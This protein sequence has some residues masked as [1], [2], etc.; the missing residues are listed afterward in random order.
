[1]LAQL[2]DLHPN[3]V[4]V[5]FRHFPLLSIHDKASLAGQA[6][7][8]AGAQ[9][10]FWEMH[11]F[12]FD[13]YDEWTPLSPEEF[14]A[15]LKDA[16]VALGLEANQFA[17]DLDSAKYEPMMEQAFT[18]SL[19]SGLTGTPAILINGA[20]FRLSPELSVLEATVR[21]LLLEEMQFEVYPEMTITPGEDFIARLKLDTGE[22]VIQLY[23]DEAPQAVNSFIFLAQSGWYDGN[24][25][26]L[27]I[28]ETL[29][30][31][32]DPSGTGF[33]DPG[34]HFSTEISQDLTFDKPGMVA[35]TSNGPD[36]N[37]S[38]FFITLSSLPELDGLHTIIGRVI[39]GLDLLEALEARDPLEDIFLA[40]DAR[41]DE[42][43]IEEQ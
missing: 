41:I 2:E 21:L 26:H 25:I 40:P 34:Y 12:L 4:Q 22:V 42:I 14:I 37:G 1:M 5:V 8:A 9:G 15:W 29:V 39:S 38:K 32:G 33:G 11:D 20:L 35:I 28:P 36:T 27:V 6:A 19:A 23:S 17:E 24:I 30:E 7:E 10:A 3:D 13:R 31:T 43:I 18:S 16:S